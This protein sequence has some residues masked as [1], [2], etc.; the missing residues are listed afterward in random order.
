MGDGLVERMNRSLLHLL[1]ALVEKESEWE[2]HVQ[3]L[4]FVYRTTK[5]STT[6]LSPYEI[7]FGQNPASPHLAT[8][9]VVTIYDPADYSSQLQ[10]KLLELT[11]MVEA[12]IMEATIKQKDYYKGREPVKLRPGQQ[13]LLEDPT[14]GKLDPRWTGPWEVEEFREP[15]TVKIKRG[16]STRVVHINRTRLLLQ[17]EIDEAPLSKTW[18][19]PCF[20][21][22]E[23][24]SADQDGDTQENNRDSGRGPHVVTRSGRV[25]R[26]PDYYGH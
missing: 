26:P 22:S 8:P 21:Y 3:L 6:K 2:E 10:R 17:G 25:V 18:N 24:S 19:P 7:L 14:R 1:R 9:P 16:N 5:H 20:N 15:S 4:L 11:E 23:D 12:N 13:V